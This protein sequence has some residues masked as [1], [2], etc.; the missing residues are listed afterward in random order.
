MDDSLGKTV[1]HV[2]G[3][4]GLSCILYRNIARHQTVIAFDI[5]HSNA[6]HIAGNALKIWNGKTVSLPKK[7]LVRI[8]GKLL[9]TKGKKSAAE[10]L[11][12]LNTYKANYELD[13]EDLIKLGYEFLGD[14]NPYRLPVKPNYDFAVETFKQNVKFFPDYWNSYDSLADAPA[15]TG[16]TDSAIKMYRKSIELNPNNEGGKKALQKLLESKNK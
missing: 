15:R 11:E 12:K 4:I 14:V 10:T 9:V 1:F 6:A 16:E 5:A 8:Y 13:K 7:K 2:G 3:S